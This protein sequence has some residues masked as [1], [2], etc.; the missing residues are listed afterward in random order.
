MSLQRMQH[1]NLKRQHQSR[2]QPLQQR[3]D[4]V[5]PNRKRKK[6]RKVMANPDDLSVGVFYETTTNPHL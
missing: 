1:R 6:A 3:R 4:H 5:K 2:K